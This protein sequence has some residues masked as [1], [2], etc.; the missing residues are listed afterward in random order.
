MGKECKK[1]VV[2]YEGKYYEVGEFLDKHPGGAP[3]LERYNGRDITKVFDAIGHSLEARRIME[4]YKVNHSASHSVNQ[5]V[6]ETDL[7]PRAS[8]DKVVVTYQGAK[9]DVTSFVDEHPAGRGIIVKHNGKDI[10][11]PFNDVGHSMEARKMM[12]KFAVDKK[13]SRSSDLT[14]VPCH[15]RVYKRL[16]SE[17]DK[18]FIHK[19]FG[20]L[21]LLNFFYRY[22]YLLPTTGSLGFQERSLFN[23]GCLLIHALLSCTSLIFHVL[24]R[25]L[26]NNALIIYEEYRLHAIVFSLRATG[27]SFIGMYLHLLPASLLFRRCF[28]GFFMFFI[29]QVVDWITRRYGTPGVTAVRNDNSGFMR[30]RRLFF[31]YYQFCAIAAHLVLDDNLCDLGWNAMGAIQSSAFLMTL[32]RKGLIRWQ[33]HAFW[34]GLAL[35]LSLYYMYIAKG[36]YFFVW[37]AAAF[38]ARLNLTVSKYMIWLWFAV[39]WYAS[40][41]FA[42]E[43]YGEYLDAYGQMDFSDLMGDAYTQAVTENPL[44]TTVMSSLSSLS[45]ISVMVG[46]LDME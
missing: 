27:V 44:V 16:V 6:S 39:L 17:E 34:Y 19:A 25:R 2:Q 28:L 4:K 23:I 13:A 35:V 38:T 42:V 8:P 9:Y 15:T 22:L 30:K 32:K 10:T 18:Y 21:S 41:S 43:K 31:S 40:E 26:K 24:E 12:L 37:A 11:K 7:D 3:A 1:V 33:S 29:H 36:F 46:Q 5:K 45:L 20:I 14:A